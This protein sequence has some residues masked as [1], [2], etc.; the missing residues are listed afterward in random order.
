MVIIMKYPTI[1]VCTLLFAGIALLMP[2]S[3]SDWAQFQKDQVN[4]GWTADSGPISDPIAAWNKQTTGT[5]MGGID[6]AP[7][8]AGDQVFVV[9][10]QAIVWAYDKTTGEENWHTSCSQPGTYELSTPAYHNGILYVATSAGDFNQ[11]YCKVTALNVNNGVIRE[12][13]TLR[14]EDG[15]QLNTPVTYSDGKIYVGEWSGSTTSTNGTGTYYCLDAN[16]VTQILWEY[17]SDR[18]TGYY[19]AGAAIVGDY[20]LFGDD[21]AIVT[22]LNK[23]DGTLVDYIDISK[24]CGCSDPV[25]RIRSSILW[26]AGTGHI[27]FTA[28]NRDN[29]NGGYGTGHLYAVPFNSA[30]GDLGSDNALGGGSCKWSYDLWNSKSTP[31]YYDGRIYVGGG[32]KMYTSKQDG[33]ICCIDETD[34]SL[35]WEWTS[36]N[37]RV[38]ASPAL[39]VV[40]GRKFIYYTTNVY[41]GSAYCLEDM[42]DTYETRWVWNPPAPDNQYFLHGMAI[43]DGF[44]YCGTDYG[45]FY[46][47]QSD[48]KEEWFGEGSN[49]GTDVTTTEVQDAIHRWLD[50]LPVRGYI[51]SLPDLQEIIAKWLM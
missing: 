51:L 34:G 28:N 45:R 7:I 12:S 4:T 19:W 43:S 35:I 44:V 37:G 6:V 22:C 11:G 49:G 42:G 21:T 46:A 40:D 18:T 13:K 39:S 17:Q 26:N 31:V 30:T 25:E 38:K 48:W 27:Y 8:I 15:F 10:Y 23:N 16:D 29:A 24:H 14:I 1:I 41:D 32:Y 20:I 9:D 33:K 36:S 50:G 47:L 5:G 3:A 2:A